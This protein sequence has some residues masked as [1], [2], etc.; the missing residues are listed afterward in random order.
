M[1]IF[2]NYH[3]EEVNY[4]ASFKKAFFLFA[5]PSGSVKFHTVAFWCFM[6]LC[7]HK[8]VCAICPCDLRNNSPSVFVS[9]LSTDAETEKLTRAD[10]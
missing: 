5:F 2:H 1:D 9:H 8:L 6:S 7:F 3:I 4:W 10:N